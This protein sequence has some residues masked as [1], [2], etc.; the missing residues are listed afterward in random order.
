MIS[1]VRDLLVGFRV[2]TDLIVRNIIV[3]L[4]F[5]W[6]ILLSLKP[7]DGRAIMQSAAVN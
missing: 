3:F 5:P 4:L 7:N 6:V 2:S 1:C